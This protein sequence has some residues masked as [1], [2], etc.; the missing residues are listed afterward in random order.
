MGHSGKLLHHGHN[1]R[2]SGFIIGTQ[3]GGTVGGN[4]GA[5]LELRQ[6]REIGHAKHP[7][8]RSQRDIPSVVVFNNLRIRRGIAEI[9]YRIH[10]SNQADCRP[11]LLPRRWGNVSVYVTVFIYKSIGYAKCLQLRDQFMGKI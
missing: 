10:M 6:V 5:S 9:R 1:L 3:N 11:F 2:D 4:Q 7:A 8:A